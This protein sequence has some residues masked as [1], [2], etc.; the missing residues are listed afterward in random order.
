MN[1][2]I[3]KN[4]LKKEK[5]FSSQR[6]TKNKPVYVRIDGRSFSNFTKHLKKPFDMDF[7]KLM[8]FVTT[9]L[10]EETDALLGYTQSDEI[11]LLF[12]S[13]GNSDIFFQ[14]RIQKM[15]SNLAALA[16]ARFL[17]GAMKLWPEKCEE[18]LPTF[19]CKLTQL[20]TLDEA[21]AMFSFRENDAVK[22]SINM[23]SRMFF[24]HNEMMNISCDQQIERLKAIGEDWE[25]YPDIFKYGAYVKRVKRKSPMDEDTLSKIP[26]EKIPL[27]KCFYRTF[28]EYVDLFP[29]ADNK[30]FLFANDNIK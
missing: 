15:L 26:K 4:V 8:V 17:K 27:D 30:S 12:Y 16:T 22:N 18:R 6:T 23:L 14:G 21:F 29:I 5:A 20:D 24:T 10:V 9:Y 2:D 13:R 7:R 25:K 28:V 19:D 1:A 11:S 3:I